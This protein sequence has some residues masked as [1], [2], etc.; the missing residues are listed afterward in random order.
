VLARRK[1]C[2]ASISVSSNHS[3]AVV[4]TTPKR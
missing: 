2:Q 3:G 4:M 1:A